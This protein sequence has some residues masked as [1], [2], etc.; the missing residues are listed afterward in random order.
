M[1]YM[2]IGLSLLLAAFSTAANAQVEFRLAYMEKNPN[3]IAATFPNDQLFRF[4]AATP[5]VHSSELKSASVLLQDGRAVVHIRIADSARRNINRLVAANLKSQA[6]R[7]LDGH[8]WARCAVK[9]AR[10]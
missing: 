7:S 2:Q 8:C 10:L 6:T 5:Y 9:W 1:N 3:T 4:M